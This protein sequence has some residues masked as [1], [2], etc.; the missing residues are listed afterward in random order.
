M[1][2]TSRFRCSVGGAIVGRNPEGRIMKTL[3]KKGRRQQWCRP[4]VKMNPSTER[5]TSACLQIKP[6]PNI[7]TAAGASSLPGIDETKTREMQKGKFW[8]QCRSDHGGAFPRN[9]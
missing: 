7:D 1:A 5:G 9:V 6:P 8:G 4:R 2:S 3:E